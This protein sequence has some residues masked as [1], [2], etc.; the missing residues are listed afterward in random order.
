MRARALLIA[1]LPLAAGCLASPPLDADPAAAA[2]SAPLD[3][4]LALWTAGAPSANLRLLGEFRDGNGQ[5][6]DAWGDYLFVDRGSAVRIL[7]V[8]DPGNVTEV[9]VVDDVPGVLDVKV[10]DDGAWLFVGEDAEGSSPPLGGTGPFTGGIYVV[11]VTDKTA[12][13]V[14]SY[15]PIGP[16]RGPH[17]VTYHRTASGDEL[18][19]GANADV[20]INRFDRAAGTL[21]ELARYAPDFVTG[22]N[23]DPQ[24]FDVLYQGW[25]HDTFAMDEPD[26]STY[27]YVANWDAGLRIVDV[28]DPARPVELGGWNAFPDGHEGNLHTVSAAWIGER[29]IV[30]GA[31]EVGFAVVGGYHYALG[32]D[33]SVV[34]VWDATDPAAIALLGA[35]ENPD[36]APS[37][38]DYVPGEGVTSTH[39]LQ[40]EGGRVYLAHY[41]LGVFVLDVSTPDAQAAPGTLAFYR[42][43]GMDTWDVVLNRGVTWTSG[44]EGVL[45]MAFARDVVGPDG[46]AS[47]A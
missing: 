27:L 11:N 29:R 9:G 24:V 21:T 41:G 23:R 25:A 30:V 8:T 1:L 39:N 32:T 33:R 40:L 6:A 34:Y 17:M 37:G 13:V 15:L 42:E 28:T 45:A 4:A 26:G 47:R 2:V 31:V 36:R 16:R 20:S 35:W 5:E 7:D 46:A 3:D 18:V 43:D 19:F 10:S 22:F 38:R 44:V 14:Q 12:P